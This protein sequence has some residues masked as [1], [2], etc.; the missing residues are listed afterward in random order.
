V[1]AGLAALLFHVLSE[2][3]ELRSS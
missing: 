1:T 2:L 3:S